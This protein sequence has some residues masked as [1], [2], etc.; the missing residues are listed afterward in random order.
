MDKSFTQLGSIESI[1]MISFLV[2]KV[3]GHTLELF[4]GRKCCTILSSGRGDSL[5][6]S[7][8]ANPLKS[9]QLTLLL[10]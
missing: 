5:L 7:L 1:E 3:V 10:L 9:I 4:I 6:A 8:L 2:L